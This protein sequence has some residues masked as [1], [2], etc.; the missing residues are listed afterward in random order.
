MY[1]NEIKLTFFPLDWSA[2]GPAA[3]S[4]AEGGTFALSKSSRAPERNIN[5]ILNSSE[6]RPTS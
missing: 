3:A 4:G 5:L 6:K 2:L 1:K